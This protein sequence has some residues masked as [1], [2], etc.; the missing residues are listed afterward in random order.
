MSPQHGCWET[1]NQWSHCR[2]SRPGAVETHIDVG[3]AELWI[4]GAQIAYVTAQLK[5]SSLREAY[6]RVAIQVD[7]FQTNGGHIGG[8]SLGQRATVG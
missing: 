5:L 3:L 8:V 2:R 6:Q 4:G 7:N 1:R